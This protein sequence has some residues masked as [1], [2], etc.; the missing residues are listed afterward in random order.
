LARRRAGVEHAE[1]LGG[2]HDGGRRLDGG[3]GDLLERLPE[4]LQLELGRLL[5]LAR[6]P[7]APASKMFSFWAVL[8]TVGAAWTAVLAIFWNVFQKLCSELGGSSLWPAAP[9][10]PASKMFSFWA[11]LMTVGARLDGGLGDLWTSSRSSAARARTAPR[12]GPPPPARRPR[13]CSASGR[14]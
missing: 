7:R 10:A 9:G 12:S 4:A 3:L 11:V 14:C 2:V 1:L 13:R 5:A 8:M 6:R